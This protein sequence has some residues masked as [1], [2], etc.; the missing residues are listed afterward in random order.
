MT[1]IRALGGMSLSGDRSSLP[2]EVLSDTPE[3][4]TCASQEFAKPFPLIWQFRKCIPAAGADSAPVS[5][6]NSDPGSDTE[7]PRPDAWR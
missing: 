4:F 3:K 1:G 7:S 6:N 2:N 5:S